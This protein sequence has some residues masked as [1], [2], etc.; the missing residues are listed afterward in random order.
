[1][2]DL[3]ADDGTSDFPDTSERSDEPKSPKSPEAGSTKGDLKRSLLHKVAQLTRVVNH[4]NSKS[5]EQEMEHTRLSEEVEAK[6][7]KLHEDAAQAMRAEASKLEEL[8]SKTC[9]QDSSARLERPLRSTEGRTGSRN[10]SL[11]D[12]GLWQP[13]VCY[14]QG[15]LRSVCFDPACSGHLTTGSP[16]FRCLQGDLEAP[17]GGD[18]AA[19]RGARSSKSA[20]E[21][22][23]WTQRE[24][25]AEQARLL[26][27]TGSIG[28][29]PG[30]HASMV[31]RA[32]AN[33][34]CLALTV[35]FRHASRSAKD[36][37][38]A[39]PLFCCITRLSCRN[40]E[41]VQ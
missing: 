10:T 15:R 5:D 3:H 6:I 13:G 38:K 27:R 33:Q 21:K 32:Y 31:T 34:S 18:G 24:E 8:A 36:E 40:P 35:D 26:S 4:L 22:E 25:H 39:K 29:G 2:G 41:H 16:K 20:S 30:L 1:M 37:Y 19:Q 28:A 23:R 11:E 17:G 14:C 7:Q 12:H 9:L